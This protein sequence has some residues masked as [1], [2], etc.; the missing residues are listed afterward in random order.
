MFNNNG[1]RMR[2]GLKGTMLRA[3]SELNHFSGHLLNDPTTP[4]LSIDVK[5][6]DP[7][8][9]KYSVKNLVPGPG[10]AMNCHVIVGNCIN[11]LQ[12]HLKGPVKNWSATNVLHIDTSAGAEMNAYY[13]RSSLKFFYYSFGGRNTYFADSADI[14]A[15]EL[16]HAFL[17]AMRPDFWSVQSLEIWSFHEAFSD[18]VAMFNLMNYD[19]A[20]NK[21]LEQTKGEI[22]V[23]NTISRLAEEVGLLIRGL[24]GDE[25]Y[26]PNA[27]RDP[28]VEHFA[29]QN[30]SSLPAESPNNRLAAECHSFG[31]VFSNAWYHIFARTF[32]SNL[33]RTGNMVESFKDA[34]DLCFSSLIQAVPISARTVNY[35]QSVAKS[36]IT[37]A[38]SK[39]PGFSSIVKDV[40]SE[41]NI[42]EPRPVSTLSENSRRRVIS[43]L[44]KT[45]IV[46]K[47][48]ERTSVCLRKNV[49]LKASELPLVSGLSL[50]RDFEVEVAADTHYEFDKDGNL[51]GE[52][53]P[54]EDEIRKSAALC[55]S[56]ISGLIG[57]D[58]DSRWV[59]EDGRLKRTIIS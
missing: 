30:P 2:S 21:V 47:N 37:I 43:E 34:R 36:M 10:R 16:G 46:Y 11:K 23:S 5:E 40:F 49:F 44:K 35:Y 51:V 54:D 33:E 31:R 20:I 13:D 12:S 29:Y 48:S 45:D 32:K 22:L 56:S 7:G 28:A 27:L 4:D 42:C 8:I 39:D 3:M 19:A 41:W 58:K 52:M 55:L 26:L 6:P 53:L 57:K 17:D 59:V 25:S 9:L 14:V 1:R 38:E 18:I 24:T 50:G 15:H